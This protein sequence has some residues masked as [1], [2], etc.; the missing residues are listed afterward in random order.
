MIGCRPWVVAM[1]KNAKRFGPISLP[2][3]GPACLFAARDKTV[4]VHMFPAEKLIEQGISVKNYEHFAG[5][6]EGAKLLKT[7]SHTIMV[8]ADC[9]VFIPAGHIVAACFYKAP[10]KKGKDNI[11]MACA[12]L[13]PIPF[14]TS[15]G[16]MSE[17]LKKA[18]LQWHEDQTKEKTMTMWVERKK[19]L[20][21]VLKCAS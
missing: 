2:S 11:D 4:Y 20:K 16:G 7:S 5:T 15:L 8:P 19:F 1:K 13:A 17:P 14:A 3:P 12:V 6:P 10:E 9:I 18:L 21:E